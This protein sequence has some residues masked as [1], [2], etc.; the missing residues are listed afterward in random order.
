MFCSECGK[1]AQGKFCCHCGSPLVVAATLLQPGESTPVAIDWDHEVRYELLMRDPQVR[2]AV[3]AHARQAPK[4]MSAEQ[5]LALADKLVP[6]PVSMEGMAAI[7]QP[8]WAKLGVRTGKNLTA[9]LEAPVARVIVRALCSLAHRGQPL[10]DV[11]QGEHGV[12]LEAELPSDLWSMA[13]SL[14]VSLWRSRRGTGVSA[15][16]KIDGQ[17]IDWGKSRRCL[18]QLIHDLRQIDLRL[19]VA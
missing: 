18:E 1:S 5:F 16:T 15:S 11:S 7:A 12:S 17:W 9:Q 10:R 14:H 4:R 2:A 8:L 3:D 19:A 6:Q 13:G